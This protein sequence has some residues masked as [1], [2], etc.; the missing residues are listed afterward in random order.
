M[1]VRGL[2]TDAIKLP[3]SAILIAISKTLY[4]RELAITEKKV[5]PAD[6]M[7][8]PSLILGKQVIHVLP[9]G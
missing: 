5:K 8:N 7:H 4:D 1:L 3:F 6:V 2:R 9:E